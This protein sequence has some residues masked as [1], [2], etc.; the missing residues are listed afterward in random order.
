MIV[1]M[2]GSHRVAMITLAKVVRRAKIVPL[3]GMWVARITRVEMIL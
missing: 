1:L 2:A 3:A